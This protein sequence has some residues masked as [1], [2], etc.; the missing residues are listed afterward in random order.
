[1]AHELVVHNIY[2]EVDKCNKCYLRELH[3]NAT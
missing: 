3:K 2:V 1:M